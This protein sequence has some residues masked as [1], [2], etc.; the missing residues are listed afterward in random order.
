MDDA[1][2]FPVRAGQRVREIET[3]TGLSSDLRHER[4]RRH[5]APALEPPPQQPPHVEA[6]DRLH[7]DVVAAFL[8]G[9]VEDLD[10]VGVDQSGRDLRLVD[11]HAHELGRLGQARVDPLDDERS[12]EALGTFPDRAEDFRHAA[13]PDLLREPVFHHHERPWDAT[14]KRSMNLLARSRSHCKGAG[15][16][17]EVR[18][19][20]ARPGGRN[21]P[22][23]RNRR[24]FRVDF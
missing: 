12:L 18:H 13:T 16:L 21:P 6:L 23:A 14:A 3:A 22:Q 5:L 9:E 7:D 2:R 19:T 1:Q 15:R 4:G 20:P 17:A 8:R 24:G 11:E 10:D